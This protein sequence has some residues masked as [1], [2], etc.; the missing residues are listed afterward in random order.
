V[1][2]EPFSCV[3]DAAATVVC[4]AQ[5][6]IEVGTG[7]TFTINLPP[8]KREFCCTRFSSLIQIGL[9]QVWLPRAETTENRRGLEPLSLRHAICLSGC[10]F[11]LWLR[12]NFRRGWVPVSHLLVR[13]LETRDIPRDLSRRPMQSWCWEALQGRPSRRSPPFI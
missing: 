6:G 2:C 11:S 3:K 10:S 4:C 12:L 1:R 7:A 5:I 13:P 9:A 8:E